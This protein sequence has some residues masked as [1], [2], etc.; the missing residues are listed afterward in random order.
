VE[1]KNIVQ[2][3][4]RNNMTRKEMYMKSEVNVERKNESGEIIGFH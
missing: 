4:E 3:V 1:R 2:S